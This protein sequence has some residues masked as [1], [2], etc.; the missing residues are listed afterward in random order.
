MRTGAG[1]GAAAEAGRRARRPGRPAPHGTITH[2]ARSA[3]ALLSGLNR[4]PVP[5]RA[6]DSCAEPVPGASDFRRSSAVFSVLRRSSV[7][8]GNLRLLTFDTGGRE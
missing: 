6:G 3:A 7:L 8:F 4:L 2:S 1:D 5:V